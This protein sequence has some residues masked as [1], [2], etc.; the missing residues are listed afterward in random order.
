[1]AGGQKKNSSRSIFFEKDLQLI[2]HSWRIDLF[3]KI[4]HIGGFRRGSTAFRLMWMRLMSL[5][6]LHALSRHAANIRTGAGVF[7]QALAMLQCGRSA[8]TRTRRE[9]PL[10]KAGQANGCPQ[11]ES[12][13]ADTQLRTSHKE[14]MS[15]TLQEM[16]CFAQWSPLAL[17]QLMA[18]SR[19]C[20][21]ER[22]STL[23][24]DAEVDKP[25]IFVIVSGHVLH[26]EAPRD[27]ARMNWALRGPRH[28][29]GFSYML[30]LGSRRLEYVANDEVVAIHISGHLLFAFLDED[31][32]RWKDMSRMLLQQERMQ[33]DLVAGQTAGSFAQRLAT[34]V[35]QLAALYGIQV[36]DSSAVH[37]RL[38]Q[39][40]LAD[41]LQ[42]S[43]Q[44]VNAQMSTWVALGVVEAQYNGILILDPPALRKISGPTA[45][46]KDGI[47]V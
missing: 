27:N 35:E 43:R 18:S 25:E 28:I 40:T 7:V 45:L 2:M 14:L 11:Q 24:A 19:L 39:Q 32:V 36:K 47:C 41:I 16:P 15:R 12:H 34:T 31:P 4:R 33:I 3:L 22:G 13:V 17:N 30:D 38:T 20:W 9:P 5:G 23:S 26:V 44:S 42:V 46:L 6:M 21:H 1:M 10:G 8:G 29:L 37:L